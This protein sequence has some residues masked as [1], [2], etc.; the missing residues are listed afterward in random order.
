MVIIIISY[1]C[2]LS[3]CIAAWH[4]QMSNLYLSL[5]NYNSSHPHI[6]CT[7]GYGAAYLCSASSSTSKI[8][9][10]ARLGC[11]WIWLTCTGTHITITLS[12]YSTSAILSGY[13]SATSTVPPT[14]VD[15]CDSVYP[16][17]PYIRIEG[18]S[19]GHSLVTQK[20]TTLQN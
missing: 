19:F 15:I 10:T 18:A 16:L 1:C 8:S 6:L 17:S 14:V 9:K 4:S 11:S 2:N 7:V 3:C 13:A 20:K 5:P 12:R